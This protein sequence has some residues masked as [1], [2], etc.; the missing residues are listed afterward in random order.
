MFLILFAFS[1][2]LEFP[3][4]DAALMTTLG[5]L[6]HI[7]LRGVCPPPPSLLHVK[8]TNWFVF[9]G[10][11]SPNLSLSELQASNL[12]PAFLLFHV[13]CAKGP[14]LKVSMGTQIHQ[15]FS[16]WIILPEHHGFT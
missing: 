16:I 3:F 1:K 12:S 5:A 4:K 7:L 13:F 6:W 9:G 8:K 11:F 15:K 10:C 2:M 14:Y